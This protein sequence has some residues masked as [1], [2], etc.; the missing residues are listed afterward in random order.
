MV[1][2]RFWLNTLASGCRQA[3]DARHGQRRS[4]HRQHD[5]AH[6]HRGLVRRAGQGDQSQH[7][8][9]DVLQGVRLQAE[10]AVVGVAASQVGGRVAEE[11][12]AD[13]APDEEEGP[14]DQQGHLR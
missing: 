9:D 5:A 1:T 6:A 14:E 3:D 10:Q 7:D 4:G 11:E 2:A 12:E 8:V 13:D